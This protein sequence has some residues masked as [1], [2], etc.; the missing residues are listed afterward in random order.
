MAVVYKD[1]H[2][3]IVIE[4]GSSY[5]V[6]IEGRRD[7][8]SRFKRDILELPVV[9]IP[10][11]DLALSKAC[12]QALPFNFRIDMPVGHKEIGPAIVINVDKQCAPPQKLR[13]RT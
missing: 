10:I 2:G 3:T 1:L 4:I 13:I 7:T 9:L 5:A 8:W 6:T 11:E 12:T